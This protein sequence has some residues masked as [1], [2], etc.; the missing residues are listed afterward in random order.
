MKTVL[1]TGAS[2]GIGRATAIALSG[3][4]FNLVLIAR[5]K[6]KLDQLASQ[7]AASGGKALVVAGDVTKREDLVAAADLALKEFGSI[8][9]LINN[10]GIMPLSFM[11]NLHQDE[12]EQMIDVNIKG[13]LNGIGAVLPAMKEQKSGHI[14]NISSI[15][16]E[17]V[18][19]GSA[20]YS[21]TKFAVEAITEGVRAEMSVPFNIRTTAIRPGTTASELTQ[22]ITDTEV[23]DVL[24][25]EMSKIQPIGAEDI[26]NSIVYAVNQPA[27]VNVNAIVVRPTS[28]AL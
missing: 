25:E 27:N 3:Y 17:L 10:A 21:A 19:P 22:T 24:G 13:V 18:F 1:L 20:V 2:S 16:G 28:Q 7:I 4:G 26:A 11:K 8:D 9:V 12:W 6:D 14:I 23:F 15:A 5:S